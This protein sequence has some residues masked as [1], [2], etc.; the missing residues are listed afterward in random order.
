MDL[1]WAASPL[2]VRE[3][4]ARLELADRKLAYTTVMT[5]LDRLFKKSLLRRHAENLAF[6][7][8]PALSKDDYRRRV[9]EGVVSDLLEH[10]EGTEPVLAAFVDT[11]AELGEE[12]LK[13]LEE[14]VA[15]RRRAGR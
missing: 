15:E 8:E 4:A 1:L 11:T 2:T 9:L 6:T 10:S 5:T 12:T 3:V 13:R 14:L 7:Y